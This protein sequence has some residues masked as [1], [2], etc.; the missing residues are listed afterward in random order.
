MASTAAKA[1]GVTA[2]CACPGRR[3]SVTDLIALMNFLVHW[4]TCCGD[5]HASSYWKFIRRWISKGFEP[6]TMK[7]DD[8]T[9]FFG[10]CC[11]RPLFKPWVSLLSAYET[12][13]M[14]MEFLSHF[15]FFIWLS[16][17]CVCV[18]IYTYLYLFM[19]VLHLTHWFVTM[20]R[21]H[22][23]YQMTECKC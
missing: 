10:A 9:V 16:L 15:H 8:R 1:C 22:Y 14:C 11:K 12:I 6:V 13:E 21:H 19:C 18:C 2:G 23:I 7:K 17:V 4:Y 3:D 5:R 20:W